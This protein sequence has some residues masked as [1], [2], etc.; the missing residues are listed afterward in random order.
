MT[1]SGTSEQG[2][3]LSVVSAA[4]NEADNL[5]GLMKEIVGTFQDLGRPWEVI[6]VNDGSSD[7]TAEVLRD[8][9]ATH[10]ELRIFNLD[11]RYGQT[12]ALDAGLR[13]ARGQFIATL[14]ADL[15]NDPKDIPRLLDLLQKENVDLVNGW[16]ADRR[17]PWLRLVST[18]VANAVRNRLTH[19]DIHDSACGL[20]VFR[21]QC[22][23]RIKLFTGLHRFLPTLFKMEGFRVLEVPVHHRPRHAGK[24][25]YGVWNRLFKALR[26][27]FAIRWMQSRTFH[28]RIEELRRPSKP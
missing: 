16:R 28:Y 22:L 24:A 18:R 6:L 2:C 13:Q 1:S 21:R 8:L 9:M 26:D 27:T 20:K 7:G 11:R 3:H 12:A 15:Q 4:Y 14:D 23:S 10:P 5:P 19:E 25:K 17:D